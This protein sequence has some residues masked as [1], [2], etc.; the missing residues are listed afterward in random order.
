M[1][2]QSASIAADAPSISEFLC[3]L[4]NATVPKCVKSPQEFTTP[5]NWRDMCNHLALVPWSLACNL[6]LA[7]K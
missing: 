4:V 7:N 5:A 6:F 2:G 3:R 1:H